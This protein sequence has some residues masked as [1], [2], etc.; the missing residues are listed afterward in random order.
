VDQELKQAGLNIVYLQF[1]GM[2]NLPYEKLRGT[3]LLEEKLKVVEICRSVNLEV[4]LVPTLARGINDAEIGDI[5]RF[6]ASNSDI[7][8]GVVFQ[9]ISFNGRNSLF[10]ERDNAVMSHFAEETEN[11][12]TGKSVSKIFFQ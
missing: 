10:T 2:T 7:V 4:I 5:I 3:D 9:P 1:D 11:K 8:R 12:H 6:A